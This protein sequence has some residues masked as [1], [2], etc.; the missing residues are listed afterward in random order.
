MRA[1]KLSRS[2]FRISF[3]TPLVPIRSIHRCSFR[4]PGEKEGSLIS[5]AN[6]AQC[7][8]RVEFALRRLLWPFTSADR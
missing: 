3:I 8:Q 1:G 7:A 2:A 6:A 5:Y 4:V